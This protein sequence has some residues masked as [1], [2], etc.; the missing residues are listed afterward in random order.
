MLM[1]NPGGH[2]TAHGDAPW[3]ARGDKPLSIVIHDGATGKK[4]ACA[5][6]G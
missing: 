4:I 1:T 6:L 2:V 5:D 3:V